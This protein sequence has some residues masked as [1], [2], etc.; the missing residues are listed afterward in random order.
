MKTTTQGSCQNG[1]HIVKLASVFSKTTFNF[2]SIKA[3]KI[4]FNFVDFEK[5]E[6]LTTNFFWNFILLL[7][8]NSFIYYK[9]WLLN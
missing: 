5:K 7:L 6:I 3:S 1:F 8:H 9:W 2:K 4:K